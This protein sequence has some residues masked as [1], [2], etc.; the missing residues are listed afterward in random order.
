MH[1]S[2]Q[3]PLMAFPQGHRPARS[4]QQ[5]LTKT[6]MSLGALVTVPDGEMSSEMCCTVTAVRWT[7]A[8][9]LMT[10]WPGC[11]C[12]GQQLPGETSGCNQNA[13]A[14]KCERALGPTQLLM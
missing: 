11:P 13:R 2:K 12:K 3:V 1:K 6:A 10:T 4:A 8:G 9:N 7:R 5:R 14:M